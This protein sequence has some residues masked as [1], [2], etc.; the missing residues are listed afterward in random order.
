MGIKVTRKTFKAGGDSRAVVLPAGW[1]SYYGT[2]AAE[3]LII[4]SDLLIIGPAGLEHR[5]EEVA[6]YMDRRP[7]AIIGQLKT[8]GLG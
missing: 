3:V 7:A 4:G 1:I 6:T 8:G 5:A 2:R